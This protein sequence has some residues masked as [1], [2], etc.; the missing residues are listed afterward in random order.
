MEDQRLG[1]GV[2]P[3]VPGYKMF[4][5]SYKNELLVLNTNKSLL[6]G[7]LSCVDIVKASLKKVIVASCRG[8]CGIEGN[9]FY[10]F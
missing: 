3:N 10:D 1:Y 7:L 5:I 9:D 8:L 2:N 4:F 6:L